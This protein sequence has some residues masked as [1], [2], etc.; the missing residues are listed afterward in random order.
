MGPGLEVQLFDRLTLLG[1]RW[2][3]RIS[4]IGNGEILAQSEAYSR[5]FGRNETAHRLATALDCPM[6]PE[7]KRR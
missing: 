4:D 5:P 7:R 2:Y 3:F 6:N 1:R